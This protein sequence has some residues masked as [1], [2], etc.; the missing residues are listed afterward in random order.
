MEL[1]STRQQT[2]MTVTTGRPRDGVAVDLE[3]V[4]RALGEKPFRPH[5]RFASGHA[6]TVARH[7]W[8]RRRELTREAAGDEER[9]FEVEPGVRVLVHCRWQPRRLNAPTV[10]L[11]HGLEGSSESTYV[12]GTAEKAQRAGFNALRL[13]IRTCGNTQHLAPT[14]Y[15]SG[16]SED[17]RAVIEELIAR[18]HLS[19][20]YLAGFSLGGNQSLKLAGELS[21]TAPA[22]LRGVA[23]VSPSIDLAACAD[24]I[25][26]RDNWLYNRSFLAGMRRRMLLAQQLYPERYGTG[27]LPRARSIREFDDL[28]TAPHCGFRDADDYYTR[29][30]ALQFIGRIRVP[31][32]IVHAE[33]DPFIPFEPFHHP[34]L[35]DNPNVLLLAPRHGGHVGFVAD[36]AAPDD[37]DRF[38]AENRVVEFF[39]LL[40]KSREDRNGTAE[41]SS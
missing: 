22:A 6:Q 31:T 37:P 29:A 5:R 19:E 21:D 7:F 26:R 15:H 24:R 18:D 3:A 34:S 20:I 38:W 35:R 4:G 9:L 39:R 14:L 23:A 12:L 8:P 17:L 2:T 32:L 40:S 36:Q 30:S 41:L 28:F 1:T 10:L 13:N 27:R 25:R 11:V 16:L 33:D